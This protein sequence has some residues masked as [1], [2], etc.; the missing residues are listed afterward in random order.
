MKIH[1]YLMSMALAATTLVGFTACNDDDEYEPVYVVGGE[2]GD[3]SVGFTEA[4][5][6]VKIGEENRVAVP[7][8]G[9]LAGVRAYS[10]DP[11]VAIV[12]DVNGV[13]MIEGLKNGNCRV[14]VSDADGNYETLKVSVYTTETMTLNFSNMVVSGFVGRTLAVTGVSVDLG[15]GT[16][17]ATCDDPRVTPYI[18]SESGELAVN[19]TVEDEEYTAVVT[20]SDIS[21]LTA[22]LTVNVKQATDRVKIG[23]DTREALP[24]SGD[25]TAEVVSNGTAELY[26]DASGKNYIEGLANGSAVVKAEVGDT[27]YFLT[28]SVYTTD[29]MT[30]ST[31]NLEMTTPLGIAGSNSDVSVTLGNGGYTIA[32]NNASVT[33]SIGSNSG[34][35]TINATSRATDYT[36]TLTVTDCTGLTATL[37]VTVKASMVAWT[38]EEIANIKTMSN[39]VYGA[40]KDPSDGTSPYYFN[41]YK[42]YGVWYKGEVTGDVKTIGWWGDMWGSDYGGLKIEVPADAALNVETTGKLYYA[43]SSS[44][45]YPTYTYEGNAKIIV[46][47]D[48]KI[49]VIF[50][51][52]DL[53]NERINRGY[54]VINK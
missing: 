17:S 43:Y 40:V 23:A 9:S 35:I 31:D 50:W 22:E 25:Y 51:Q 1:Y 53:E 18:D 48:S 33:A 52:I 29:V 30:L 54:A 42:N 26:T 2:Q 7:V 46:D 34:A 44:M 3:G 6:R 27:L 32:S 49:G 37:T 41:W 11:E 10:L 12:V 19:C 36:A 20:V 47:D 28:Y 21:L 38:D 15:N 39:V 16:Y 5:I 24:F 4:D 8:E 14:M 13:P 45:W